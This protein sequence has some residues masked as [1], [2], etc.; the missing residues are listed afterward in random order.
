M[1]KKVTK[2]RGSKTHGGGSKKK[3]RGA[4]NKGG[5]G[6]AGRFEHHFFRTLKSGAKS[7]KYGFKRVSRTVNTINV[8]ELDEMTD[9]LL[10]EGI[11][12]QSNDQIRVNLRNLGV[13]KLLGGGS[14]SKKMQ[15][16]VDEFSESAKLKI[17]SRGGKIEK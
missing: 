15:I 3:R 11:A 6:D 14:V 7:G 1:K 13:N 2:Y 17:E 9:D 4:G 5:R 10:K 16:I 8:G 12:T